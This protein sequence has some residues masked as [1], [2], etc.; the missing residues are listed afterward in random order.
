MLL[1]MFK[2]S[3]R[4]NSTKLPTNDDLL[5]SGEVTLKG[6]TSVDKPIFVMACGANDMPYA[7]IC[8]YVEF[9]GNYF[10]I[11]E[12]R[13]LN[14]THIEVSC[15]IDVLATFKKEILE[16]RAHVMY[17]SSHGNTDTV[18]NRITPKA[19]NM[20]SENGVT[21][22]DFFTDS[23]DYIVCVTNNEQSDMVVPYL[24]TGAEAGYLAQEL[25][26]PD[27]LEMMKQYFSNPLENVV[28]CQLTALNIGLSNLENIAV[29]N[30][31]MNTKGHRMA[32]KKIMNK[33]V[34]VKIPWNKSDFRNRKP[35][36]QVLVYLPFVGQITIDTSMLYNTK[37]LI[38]DIHAEVV[39]GNL[40][41][42]IYADYPNS[43]DASTLIGMY[44]GNCNSQL[45]IARITQYNSIQPLTSAAMIAASIATKS[46][47]TGIIGANNFID[48]FQQ[49]TQT[50]GSISS[51]LSAY[52]GRRI[53]VSVWTV[54]TNDEPNNYKDIIGLP[55]FSAVELGNLT[56]YV[57]TQNASVQAIAMEEELQEINSMLDR[58]V[59]IE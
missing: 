36:S 52:L 49:H 54:E 5:I 22:D 59:Y 57:Q 14:N 20:L 44:S 23:P 1:K 8:N 46:P 21:L 39:T 47:F 18:D 51:A 30:Y 43:A 34:S 4:I 3:K 32:L 35:Y 28:S 58:G 9:Q 40:V 27:F 15:K 24:L 13:Q 12:L 6:V 10:W 26:G 29:G 50:N 19:T 25:Y 55:Y 45:P 16:T 11:T 33:V 41:Y 42:K 48:S 37:E 56:G 17:S 38:F 7:R 31:T 2:M 53:I